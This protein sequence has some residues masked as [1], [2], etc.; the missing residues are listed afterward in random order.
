MVNIWSALAQGDSDYCAI[1]VIFNSILQIVLFAPYT[2]FFINVISDADNLALEYGNTATAVGIYLGIPLA[3]GIVTR[4]L[5]IWSLGRKRFDTVFMP[6]F[7]PLA[8]VSLWIHIFRVVPAFVHCSDSS[9]SYFSS[10][11]VPHSSVF[12]SSSSF[13]SLFKLETFCTI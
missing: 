4:F 10:L 12:C 6:I 3:A 8:L 2:I 11:R 1:L 9:F 7:G 13:Y 5:G